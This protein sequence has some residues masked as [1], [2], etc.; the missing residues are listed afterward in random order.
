MFFYLFFI[1]FC[2]NFKSDYIDN[3]IT[4]IQNLDMRN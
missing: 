3:Q 1:F 4:Y 2:E